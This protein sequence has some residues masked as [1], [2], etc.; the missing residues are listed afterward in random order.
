VKQRTE[1]PTQNSSSAGRVVDEVTKLIIW[2]NLL[3][4][5]HKTSKATL[6]LFFIINTG[7]AQETRSI[8]ATIQ[9]TLQKAE[10]LALAGNPEIQ[11]ADKRSQAAGKQVLPSYFPDD[12]TL[13][14][15]TTNP[16]MEM[17]MVGEKFGFPG[18]GGA[19]AG[20]NSAEAK[21]MQAMGDET[22]RAVVLQARRAFWEFYY[23]QKVDEILQEAQA[24]WKNL[25][26]T[27]QSKEL[28]GQWL[29]IKA[30]RAQMEAAK[31]VNEF[32]ANSRALRVSQYNLNHLFSLP[33]QTAYAMPQEPALPPLGIKE[34]DAARKA[35]TNNPEIAAY[36]RAV[37]VREAGQL[38]ANLDY[39]PDFDVWL[40]GVRN[41]NSGGFSDYGFR[42]GLSIPLF[43]PAKQAQAVG[44]ASDEL[45]AAKFDLKGK[46]DEAVHMAED[47]Y[48]NADSAW[49]ILKLYEEG[50]LLKQIRKAWT[51]TQ[52]VYRNEEMS[53]SEFV[54]TYGTYLETLTNY[55][56]AQADYG[57]ALA[58]LQYQ[59]GDVQGGKP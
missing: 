53:L 38:M 37:E 25:S 51:S 34:G 48:V 43:F 45:S 58:E 1:N 22:R 3:K 52:L 50:G 14:V 40:S 42:V 15:D 35:L 49:R 30:I 41:P 7:W 33:S 36:Q 6:V 16:G 59:I 31:A 46:Q 56:R 9:L 26:Q 11:A 23:R 13:M 55:Y 28:S 2:K 21:K 24:R 29:S 17:W 8:P 27:L 12:P 4:T 57:K 10:E 44:A 20:L 32:I 54:E 19:K 39:L 47:A 5:I 18:K